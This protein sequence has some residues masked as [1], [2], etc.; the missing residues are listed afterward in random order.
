[1]LSF[2][3]LTCLH[4][5]RV[6]IVCR[7]IN[8]STRPTTCSEPTCNN[9][10]VLCPSRIV[11]PPIAA[12]YFSGV[13][14]FIVAVFTL[15]LAMRLALVTTM[16]ARSDQSHSKLQ[17]CDL[18]SRHIDRLT[19]LLPSNWDSVEFHY[20]QLESRPIRKE[21]DL[22]PWKIMVKFLFSFYTAI[23][24]VSILPFYVSLRSKKI[25]QS[26]NNSTG[27]FVRILRIFRLVHCTFLKDG[28]SVSGIFGR[29]LWK[30]LDA[31][32]IVA[33]IIVMV[34]IV[35]GCIFY[36]AEA[37]HFRVTVDYPDGALIS[38]SAAT[39]P[40][41]DTPSPV[42][43]V[44]TAMYWAVITLTTVGYGKSNISPV[45]RE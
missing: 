37:G 26:T 41:E 7:D 11:C 18:L 14:A 2:I 38:K 10:P 15:D 33:I 5:F 45:F 25:F 22:P 21:P 42:D 32:V 24:I 6:I 44:P 9:D 12:G 28:K 43:S 3:C 27:S 40:Y 19:G 34:T 35:G 13:D 16:P 8:I 39:G 29:A 36:T 23:D 31:L 1:V 17:N 4:H 20:A 30:S